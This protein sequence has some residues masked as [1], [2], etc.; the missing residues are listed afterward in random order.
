MYAFVRQI[1]PQIEPQHREMKRRPVLGD[2]SCPARILVSGSVSRDIVPVIESPNPMT[3]A[4][5]AGHPTA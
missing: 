4:M 2:P 3:N 1:S 5:E